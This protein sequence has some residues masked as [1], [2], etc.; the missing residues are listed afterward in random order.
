MLHSIIIMF[1]RAPCIIR[2]VKSRALHLPRILLLQRLQR[3]QIIAEY[4]V[5]VKNIF[6]AHF[7]F[8]AIT[9]LRIFDQYSRFQF[10]AVFFADPGE[11]E[12]G[13]FVH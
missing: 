13:L 12:F 6:I 3:Q 1:K 9:F 5:V 2:R 11:F 7:V 4:Q 10:W 8:C